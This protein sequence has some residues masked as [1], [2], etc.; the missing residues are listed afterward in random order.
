MLYQANLANITKVLFHK[1]TFLVF[2]LKK[3]F[4]KEDPGVLTIHDFSISS[5]YLEEGRD[6]ACEMFTQKYSVYT[7]T[8]GIMWSNAALC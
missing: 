1:H 7:A 3:E 5:W 6:M 4:E 2:K 8:S